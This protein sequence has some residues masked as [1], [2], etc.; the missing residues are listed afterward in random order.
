V[1]VSVQL[2]LYLLMQIPAGLA[3]DR[4]G[5]RRTL[6]AGLALMAGGELIFAL[7]HG[8]PLA[9]TGRAL[10]GAGD[11]LTFLNVLRLAQA[12][13]PP[14]RQTLLT[15][16]TGVAGALGQLGSTVPLEAA[17]RHLGLTSSFVVIAAVTGVL[18]ALPLLGVRD[19]PRGVAPAP[20]HE[21]IARTLAQALGRAGTRQGFFI[22]MGLMAP[23]A[24]TTAV[25]GAPYIQHTQHMGGASAAS[26]LLFAVGGFVVT[27]PFVGQIAARGRGAQNAVV[28]GLGA[29]VV[30]AWATL[31]L[32]PGALVPRQ[33]LAAV[34]LLTGA[35]SAGSMIAFDVARAEAPAVA[36]GS[37][38]AI[39]NCGGFL[40]ASV[41]AVLIGRLVGAGSPDPAHYQHAMLPV[42]VIAA[43]GLAGSARHAHRRNRCAATAAA[44]AHTLSPAPG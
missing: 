2:A 29:I 40:S 34:L 20:A 38:T 35:G 26:Y 25:W 33:L 42:L 15:A 12:W 1:F 44:R 13:F 43:V 18:T 11:A 19:R 7:A 31:L 14:E 32:W 17:V 5:P 3:A 37:A 6:A 4:I 21:P 23:F 36:S 16:L 39:V 30:A 22:H 8:L 10:V 9:I 24:L 27:G 41:G 28:L